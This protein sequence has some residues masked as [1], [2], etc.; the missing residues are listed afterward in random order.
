[1]DVVQTKECAAHDASRI[2]WYL[3]ISGGRLIAINPREPRDR[4]TFDDVEG[5]W[6]CVNKKCRHAGVCPPPACD[7]PLP[8]AMLH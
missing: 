5:K 4:F 1:M 2:G 7:L 6:S 3:S 8:G